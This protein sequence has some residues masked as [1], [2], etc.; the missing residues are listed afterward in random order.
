M[1]CFFLNS[2]MSCFFSNNR[3]MPVFRIVKTRI[4]TGIFLKKFRSDPE[5]QLFPIGFVFVGLFSF[6]M[7]PIVKL[8]ISNKLF[9]I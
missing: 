6:G 8:F 3:K 5:F 9:Y 2:K 1:S 4:V 7:K